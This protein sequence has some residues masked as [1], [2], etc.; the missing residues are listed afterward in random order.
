MTGRNIS[1]G[2]SRSKPPKIEGS[3]LT[4]HVSGR[5]C[6]RLDGKLRYF[7]GSH[8]EALAAYKK[9]KA[10]LAKPARDPSQGKKPPKIEG[11]PLTPHSSGNYWTRP[12][13]NAYVDS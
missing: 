9:L 7:K 12:R 8:E 3:P 11:S 5:Y 10:E 1:R 13:G 2:G 4:P 6:A